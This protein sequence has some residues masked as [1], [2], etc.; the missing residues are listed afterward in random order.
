M[1]KYIIYVT[2]DEFNILQQ[3]GF[4]FVEE[5]PYFGSKTWVVM[6]ECDKQYLNMALKAIGRTT[7]DFMR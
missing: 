6:F 4:E 1:V 7:D 3:E 5:L 2:E